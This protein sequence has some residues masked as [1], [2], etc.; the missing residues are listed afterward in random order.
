[1]ASSRL[2]TRHLKSFERTA[3]KL[4]RQTLITGPQWFEQC[5]RI[6]VLDSYMS[7]YDTENHPENTIVFLHGN[8]TSFMA[9]YYT[10]S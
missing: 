3:N 5:K 1:M 7:Y 6:N 9:Q 10:T 8:P 4:R 2:L